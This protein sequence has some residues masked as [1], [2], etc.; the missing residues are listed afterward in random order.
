[1][2]HFLICIGCLL[3]TTLPAQIII[4]EVQLSNASTYQDELG[5]FDDWIELYNPTDVEVNIA[6]LVLKDNVDTWAIPENGS[7]TQLDPGEYLILWAD[8]EVGEGLLHTNF[9]LSAS[10]GEFLG[11]YQSDSVTVIDQV[12]LPPM[13]DD[14]SYGRCNN[15]WKSFNIVTPNA[16]NHCVTSVGGGD[17]DKVI[18]F[19]IIK[20]SFLEVSLPDEFKNAILEI[21]N[22]TGTRLVSVASNG[23]ASTIDL[24]AYSNQLIFVAVNH[25]GRHV[26]VKKV[27]LL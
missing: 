7:E 11:L 4:N 16:E 5:D 21:Y 17:I 12:D 22:I 18:S 13:N 23:S 20:S 27:A 10:N 26:W 9:K 2:K 8:D 3:C 25:Q 19:R 24:H 1:M 15:V 6:G 14:F